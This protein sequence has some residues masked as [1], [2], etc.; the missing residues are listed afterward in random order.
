MP[1]LLE[2]VVFKVSCRSA[3]EIILSVRKTQFEY[4]LNAFEN[5]HNS[6]EI[7]K[8]LYFYHILLNTVFLLIH[9]TNSF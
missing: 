5:T 7:K 2:P 4:S 1:S 9:R 3:C 6:D 8:T